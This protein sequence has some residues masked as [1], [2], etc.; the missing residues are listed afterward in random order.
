MRFEHK[1]Y[2][3]RHMKIYGG[4]GLKARDKELFRELAEEYEMSIFTGRTKEEAEC[5]SEQGTV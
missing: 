1:L 4:Y 5:K 2:E 3:G